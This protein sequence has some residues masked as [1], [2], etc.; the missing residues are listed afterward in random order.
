MVRTMNYEGW[1]VRSSSFTGQNSTSSARKEKAWTRC[2]RIYTCAVGIVL[3]R[4]WLVHLLF[5]FPSF[6]L[7]PPVR[8]GLRFLPPIENEHRPAYEHA[9]TRLR[10]LDRSRK[11][12]WWN[13][14]A[15]A[16]ALGRRMRYIEEGC[17]ESTGDLREM[18][19]ARTRTLLGRSSI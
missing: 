3:V 11:G 8:L 1:N 2:R 7:R 5:L 16:K 13:A 18:T 6:L 10:I 19:P 9:F 14:G 15:I 17:G 4:S 12:Q